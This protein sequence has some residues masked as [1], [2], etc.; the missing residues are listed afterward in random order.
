M[1][2]KFKYLN[3]YFKKFLTFMSKKI[4]KMMKF[5]SRDENT[6]YFANKITINQLPI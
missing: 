4:Y 3:N 2:E 6:F 1:Y 5:Y